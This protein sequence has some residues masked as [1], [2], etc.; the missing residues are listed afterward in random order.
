MLRRVDLLE[1]SWQADRG[2]LIPFSKSR[3][4]EAIVADIQSWS[5]IRE[6]FSD[7]LLLG[8]GASIAVSPNFGYRS[9]YE[10]ATLDSQ[11]QA[12]FDAFE[13]QDFELVLAKLWDAKQVNDALKIPSKRLTGKY[14]SVRQALIRVV[15]ER[16][17]A[18]STAE[19]HLDAIQAFMGNFEKVV[20]LNYDLIVY[21]AMMRGNGLRRGTWF[22][23]CFIGGQFDAEWKRFG[24]GYSGQEGATLVFYP[25]GNL[26]LVHGKDK[27]VRKVVRRG[28]KRADLLD[29]VVEDWKSGNGV[30]LFVSEGDSR[31]KR[32]AIAR[33]HYLNVVFREVLTD[34]RESVTIYGW[35]MGAQDQHILDQLAKSG[36]KRAAV[37]VYCAGDVEVQCERARTRLQSLNLNELV[38]FDSASPGCWNNE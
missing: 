21:W 9:L 29:I 32:K 11:T 5:A 16:H 25:H 2:G 33:S 30:P 31:R 34:L 27:I 3:F 18:Y 8:N 28:H 15:R 35:S 10:S 12:I 36:V 37:S 7:S 26:A 23:D 6:R 14:E 38:F 13:T 22:K 20:S 19:R 4:Q 1:G 17:V 24:G